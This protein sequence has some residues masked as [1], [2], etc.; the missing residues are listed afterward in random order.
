MSFKNENNT[1]L[2][3][4]NLDNQFDAFDKDEIDAFNAIDK[5]LSDSINSLDFELS[6]LNLQKKKAMENFDISYAVKF[7]DKIN[8]LNEDLLN[9]QNKVLKY[10]NEIAEKEKKYLDNYNKL[11]ADIKDK[12]IN[13]DI[14]IV[15]LIAKYGQKAVDT[16]KKNKIYS[17]LDGY[18]ANMRNDEIKNVIN[19]NADLKSALGGY[20]QDV[21]DRY[22]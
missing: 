4:N 6:S 5:E 12:N 18:F 1:Y 13:N 14:K 15:D 7:S 17:V 16:Y 22:K 19:N 20:L 9:E 8:Q 2:F 21:L 3:E 10:N 11:V